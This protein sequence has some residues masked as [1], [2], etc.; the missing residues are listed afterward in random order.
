MSSHLAT[1]IVRGV[2]VFPMALG[3]VG[4]ALLIGSTLAAWLIEGRRRA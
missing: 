2:S 1:L 3:F 4:L